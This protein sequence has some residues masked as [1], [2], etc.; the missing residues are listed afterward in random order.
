MAMYGTKVLQQ[1][2]G[3]LLILYTYLYLLEFLFY[4]SSKVAYMRSLL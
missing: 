2:H 1:Q 3:Y 4:L